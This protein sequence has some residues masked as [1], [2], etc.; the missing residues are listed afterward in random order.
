MY[1]NYIPTLL[2]FGGIDTIILS[3][4]YIYKNF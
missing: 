3:N 2:G 1:R 4:K